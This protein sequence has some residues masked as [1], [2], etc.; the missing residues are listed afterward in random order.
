MNNPEVLLV[1]SGPSGSG[2]DAIMSRL[3]RDYP[4]FRRVVTT[5]TRSKRPV[6]QEGVDYYFL[7]R[8]KF[9]NK[10]KTNEFIEYVEY[11]KNYYG[12]LKSE[13]LK[14]MDGENTIWR[15][16]PTRA[17]KIKE[18]FDST[19]EPTIAQKLTQKTVVIYLS[20]SEENRRKRLGNRGYS[21]EKLTDRL[22]EDKQ[23]WEQNQNLYQHV[24]GNN[25]SIEEAVNKVKEII[26]PLLNQA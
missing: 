23:V 20:A 26:D 5:T 10:I 3:L 4:S 1:L 18:L 19:F 14:V 17:A 12:T 2:K 25:N 21:E 7:S 13:I 16:D 22:N 24:V 11:D 9:E 8:E 15:I 6:E